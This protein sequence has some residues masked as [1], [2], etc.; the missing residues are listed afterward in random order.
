MKFKIRKLVK[1]EDLNPRNTLFGGR[2]MC[3]IDEEAAI[4]TMCQLETKN[5]VTKLISEIN[6][7]APAIQG[8]VIEIG[9]ETV[10]FGRTSITLRC[11]V[12]N[13]DTEKIIVTI[14]KMVFV[15]VDENGKP[16]AHGITNKKENI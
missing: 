14:D 8:D 6:F 4:Y 5:I 16:F 9:M 13:K 15:S 7:L 3:W 12:R 10:S 2:L 11:E 1:P